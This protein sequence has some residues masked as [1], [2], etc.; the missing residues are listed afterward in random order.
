MV[1]GGLVF[2]CPELKAIQ[3]VNRDEAAFDNHGKDMEL[4]MVDRMTR[5]PTVFQRYLDE[6]NVAI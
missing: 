5:M 1:R 3:I 2:F 4:R 6:N